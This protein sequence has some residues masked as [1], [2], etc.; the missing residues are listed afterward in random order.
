VATENRIEA[1]GGLLWRDDDGQL[2]IAVVHRDHY[3]D[4][5]LPKGKGRPG[6]SALATAVREVGEE[7]GSHVAVSR[8]LGQVRYQ[9]D[10]RAKRVRYWL[11]QHLDGEFAPGR[12]VDKLIWLPPH[13]AKL[14]LSYAGEQA[15]IDEFIATAVPTSVVALIRHAHAGKRSEWPGPDAL[16]PLDGRGRTQARAIAAISPFFAPVRIVAAGPLRCLQTVQPLAVRMGLDVE[17]DAAFSDVVSARSPESSR[18]ALAELIAAGENTAVCSQGDTIT[19]LIDQPASK[20]AVWVLGCRGT[21]IVSA[22]YYGTGA[23][24]Q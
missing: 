14:R 3:D 1:A 23:L 17:I 16:R 19:A 6:E 22:D 8:R 20:G 10:G 2:L 7:S 11:M 18:S 4:W 5:S 24:R 12:E 9:V 13:E 21:D 15:R